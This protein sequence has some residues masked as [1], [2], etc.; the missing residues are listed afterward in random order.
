M[1][2]ENISSNLTVKSFDFSQEEVKETQDNKVIS[3]IASDALK[4]TVEEKE[5]METYTSLNS[6]FFSLKEMSASGL[7]NK[8]KQDSFPW[9]SFKPKEIIDLL[10]S[11][12]VYKNRIL[13]S[14][15]FP[16]SLFASKDLME[17]LEGDNYSLVFA[18]N[19]PWSSFV[20]EDLVAL[21][22]GQNYRLVPVFMTSEN[23]P[24]SFFNKL[25]VE[26]FL[27]KG[28]YEA[29]DFANI[30]KSTNFPWSLFSKEEI[31]EYLMESRYV[32]TAMSGKSFP[33]SLF[34][35]EE[36]SFLLG[37]DEES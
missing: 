21:L 17:S 19:F 8:M 11:L 25:E 37:P 4:S 2:I 28:N 7:F 9:S 10:E 29:D 22:K 27:G 31:E 13:N 6:S 20:K 1:T 12:R 18:K 35:E 14:E 30:L 24:W 33:K 26:E 32:K 34:N 5:M 3:E 23:F 15:N 36:I 16:W